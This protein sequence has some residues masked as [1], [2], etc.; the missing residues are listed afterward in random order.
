MRRKKLS[1]LNVIDFFSSNYSC[2]KCFNNQKITKSGKKL[3]LA[4]VRG[5]Q[6]R[7]IGNNYFNSTQ[8]ICVMLINPGSGDKTPENEW[9]SLEKMHSAKT[10]K[11]KEI[12]WK[13]LM[14]TN[15]N[16][17]PK[18]GAWDDLYLKSLGLSTKKDSVAFMNMMLCASKG[19]TY[20]TN[21]MN[22]CFSEKSNKL[23]SLLSPDVLIF[24]GAQTI[25][26]AS[27][28]LYP[29]YIL[30]LSDHN[31][32]SNDKYEKYTDLNKFKNPEIAKPDGS[33][34]MT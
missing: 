12:H 8:K 23:L 5:P 30:F 15:K 21:S 19:N 34:P 14:E 13:E 25:K 10:D 17:M 1:K 20:T 18:W 28:N 6:P 7:W 22:L 26:N 4:D 9:A 29:L 24:S 11:D 31:I 16:G 2:S 27:N 3:A 33:T 32:N